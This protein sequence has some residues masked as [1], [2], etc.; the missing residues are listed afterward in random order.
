MPHEPST[1]RTV[2][3]VDGQNLYYA[4]REAFGYSYPNYDVLGLSKALCSSR[5][6]S[7]TQVRFYTGVPNPDDDWFWHGFWEKKLA[8]MGRQGIVVYSPPLRYHNRVV[9]LPDGT[10]HTYL[11]GEEK[12]IDVRI[13]LDVIRM[14]LRREYDIALI[15]SQD[16]D[17][18][19]VAEEIRTI[20]REQSRWIKIAC[21]FPFSPTSRNRRGVDR[22]DW[23]RIERPTYD[24]CL[25]RRDYRPAK[26]SGEGG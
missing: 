8:V 26:Q 23:I 22:T 5:G 16:Q 12:G 1:K 2:A 3:F 15:M 24:A 25:D 21:A 9:R 18:S 13:A 7:L 20:A 14:A 6:W 4:A 10:E 19:E 17:L 11:A